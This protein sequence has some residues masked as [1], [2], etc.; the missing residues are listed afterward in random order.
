MGEGEEG[1]IRTTIFGAPCDVR[2]P[3]TPRELRQNY[4]GCQ[5]LPTA[6]WLREILR[7]SDTGFLH[8]DEDDGD[9]DYDDEDGGVE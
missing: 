4:F 2:P 7:A 3:F 1:R 6:V 8:N 9:D 5:N